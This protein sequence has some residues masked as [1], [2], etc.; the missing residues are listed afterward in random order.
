MKLK[1]KREGI[2]IN[3][4]EATIRLTESTVHELTYAIKKAKD[5]LQGMAY[6]GLLSCRSSMKIVVRSEFSSIDFLIELEKFPNAQESW[7]YR[8]KEE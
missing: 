4:K 1:E 6:E 3:I 8:L 7:G 2:M 5:E